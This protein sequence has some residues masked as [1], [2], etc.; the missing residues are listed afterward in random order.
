MY[1]KLIYI[2]YNSWPF[3]LLIVALKS[4]WL[5]YFF[6]LCCHLLNISQVCK[7]RMNAPPLFGII[8]AQ[9]LCCEDPI[10]IDQFLLL[11][12]EHFWG[13]KHAWK[14]MKLMKTGSIVPTITFQ[15]NATQALFY[16]HVQNSVDT[17]NKL[18]TY[19]KVVPVRSPKPNR[20]S[21]ILNF[22]AVF[23]HFQALYLNKFHP[24]I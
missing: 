2:K 11:Q 10:G 3:K 13:P 4:V 20:N 12:N 5:S 7:N 14:L 16:M 19:K 9:A 22:C 8:R 24:E 6:L 23:F 17:C 15:W 18:I 21:V 1:T